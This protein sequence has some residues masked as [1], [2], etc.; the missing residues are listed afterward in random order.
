M[1]LYTK[2][3]DKGL[4]NLYDMRRVGKDDLIF[5]ALGDIDEL[6][7]NIGML[8]GMLSFQNDNVVSILRNIQALLLDIG[9]DL[10]TTMNRK[11]VILIPESEISS[12]E[13]LI[14]KFTEAVPKL[15]E[16]ILVGVTPIDAQS[17]ICRTICRRAERHMWKARFQYEKE[18]SCVFYGDDNSFIYMNR[19]SDFFFAL[20]RAL[21]GGT[22]V[23]RKNSKKK[24]SRNSP[25]STLEIEKKSL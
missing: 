1:A 19:L 18:N 22:E 9:S 13:K 17:H 3:G 24:K 25:G 12:L 21:S 4:T 10:A 6:S 14:D 20:G 11:N 5:D 8:C 16:F 23:T 2:T 15:K 7:A